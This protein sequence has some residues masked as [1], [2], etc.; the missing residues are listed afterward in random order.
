MKTFEKNKDATD[1][2]IDTTRKF[3]V[4]NGRGKDYKV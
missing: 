2:G 3:I 4:V 1:I